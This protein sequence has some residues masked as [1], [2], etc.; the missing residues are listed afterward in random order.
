MNLDADSSGFTLTW[1]QGIVQKKPLDHA[2]L[3][4]SQSDILVE[5]GG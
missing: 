4:Q 5:E 2:D 1:G 3:N